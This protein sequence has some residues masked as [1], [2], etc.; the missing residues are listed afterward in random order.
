L[1]WVAL[2]SRGL[3]LFGPA[4]ILF[5]MILLMFNKEN[6]EDQRALEAF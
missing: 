3:I 2:F 1:C 6:F 5:G 4:L